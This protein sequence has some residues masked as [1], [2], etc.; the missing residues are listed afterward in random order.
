MEV[1]ID[2]VAVITIS[3]PPINAFAVSSKLTY[4]NFN[5]NFFFFLILC[6]LIYWVFMFSYYLVE[7]ENWRSCE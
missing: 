4:L 1:G 3:N 7:G 6:C 2:G 5:C